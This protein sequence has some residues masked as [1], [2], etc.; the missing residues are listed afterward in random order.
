MR[1]TTDVGKRMAVPGS[2]ECDVRHD[3]YRDVKES[4]FE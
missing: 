3:G 4:S 1:E 2:N